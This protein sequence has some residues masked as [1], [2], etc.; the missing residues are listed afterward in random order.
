MTSISF[1]SSLDYL[2]TFLNKLKTN[3]IIKIKIGNRFKYNEVFSLHILMFKIY[4]KSKFITRS[5]IYFHVY[6]FNLTDI[7]FIHLMRV[8]CCCSNLKTL[9]F[10]ENVGEMS[11]FWS[12]KKLLSLFRLTKELEISVI[13]IKS[14]ER[15]SLDIYYYLSLLIPNC[16]REFTTYLGFSR[17]VL[18]VVRPIL[19]K[20]ELANRN[21]D[22]LTN[23]GYI[24][25]LSLTKL[26]RFYNNN[27]KIILH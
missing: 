6:N 8:L 21:R 15:Y 25:T 26:E 3:N 5:L 16:T 20:S 11:N 4:R 10:Q 18:E 22:I 17:S 23:F 27:R 1:N 2:Q 7:D 14:F 13:N 9:R 24:N 19:S 12:V